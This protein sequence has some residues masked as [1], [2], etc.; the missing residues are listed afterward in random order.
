MFRIHDLSNNHL[1]SGI[2]QRTKNINPTTVKVSLLRPLKSRS[3]Y[4]K[5]HILSARKFAT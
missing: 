3:V 1:C 5:D 4:N 2:Q